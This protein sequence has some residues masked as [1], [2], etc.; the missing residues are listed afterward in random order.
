MKKKPRRRTKAEQ[1][2][3]NM[4]RIKSKDTAIE[5]MFRRALWR[6]GI[7]YRK[8]DK[9]LPGKPD[10]VLEK[11]KIAIFCDGEFWHGKDWRFQKDSIRTNRDYWIPKIERNM[12]RDNE[13]E[14]QLAKRGWLV[15]RF[16]G[17]DIQKE[18]ALCVKEV[19]DA[20][21][22]RELDAYDVFDGYYDA[23]QAPDGGFRL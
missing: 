5:I 11:H 17:R 9:R 23:E 6:A 22:Q 19:Q 10:I 20:L 8:N 4:S 14:K 3:Y 13:I 7:R 16:W 15:L 21:F 12:R 1:R 18:L 2:R